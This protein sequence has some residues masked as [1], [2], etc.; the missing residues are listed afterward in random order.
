MC[1]AI[2]NLGDFYGEYKEQGES[3][4]E[5]ATKERAFEWRATESAP[6]ELVEIADKYNHIKNLVYSALAMFGLIMLFDYPLDK[7][8]HFFTSILNK[9]KKLEAK[10]NEISSNDNQGPKDGGK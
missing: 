4:L 6:K 1:L 2:F 9:I 5:F 3:V 7:E 8:N 10:E